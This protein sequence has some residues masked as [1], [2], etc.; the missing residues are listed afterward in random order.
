MAAVAHRLHH[1]AA[2]VIHDQT[3][4]ARKVGADIGDRLR[5]DILRCAH[6]LQNLRGKQHTHD[7]KKHACRQAKGN[8]GVNGGA[9]LFHLA[10]AEITGD[11]HAC[12][13]RDA[14]EKAHQQKD[15]GSG[16]GNRCQRTVAQQ[17]ADDKG[18]GGIVKLLE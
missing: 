4:A 5:H 16:T 9:H 14:A 8:I 18:V 11:H 13:H 6:P 7:G 12:A 15:E 17:V 10:G 1:A 3:D 2:L